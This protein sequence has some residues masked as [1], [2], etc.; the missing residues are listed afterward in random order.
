M[1]NY[2]ERVETEQPGS[3]SVSMDAT[4]RV[5]TYYLDSVVLED[6]PSAIIQILGDTVITPS[7]N[8]ALQRVMPLAHA[9]M[10]Y[11]Y[12]ASIQSI[13]GAGKFSTQD[14]TPG[15]LVDS[16]D[17]FPLYEAY[18]FTIQFT[19]RPYAVLPDSTVAQT[20]NS[21]I[22]APGDPG[23]V[24]GSTAITYN[25]VEEWN[26]YTYSYFQPLIENVTGNQGWMSFNTTAAC[27]NTYQYPGMTAMYLPNQIFKVMWYQVP[28]R[29]ITSDNSYLTRWL[30][31][32]NQKDF[33]KA[34]NGNFQQF[35]PGELLY[36][37]YSPAKIYNPPVPGDGLFPGSFATDKL[38]DIELTFI[39]TN[40]VGTNLPMA[41]S[42]GEGN[43]IIA[44]HNL[45]PWWVTR[46]FYYSESGPFT[47]TPCVANTIRTPSY[48]SFPMD[49]L[50]FDPD[51][52]NTV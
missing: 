12:A 44:G 20:T 7:G 32:I 15:L 6:Y 10:P 26:R 39:Y 5:D 13:K 22:P 45:K 38:C 31:R 8:G 41:P 42:S 35:G 19:P 16:V 1:L 50:F 33:P 43:F 47:N 29:F 23:Y 25:I 2:L 36:I 28:Y 52:D 21:W 24:N 34:A 4:S 3:A 48:L 18:N 46:K 51:V 27:P 17:E 30:G 9:Q 14:K 40:R 49:L 37:S 11:C